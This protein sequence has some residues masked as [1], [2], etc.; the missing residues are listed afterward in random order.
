MKNIF[1]IILSVA[2]G[3][4]F[5]DIKGRAG[6]AEFWVI[7]LVYCV[8]PFL[9]VNLI[10]EGSIYMVCLF[11]LVLLMPWIVWSVIVRRFHD[12]NMSGWWM[13]LILPLIILPFAEG[14]KQNNRFNAE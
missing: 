10:N 13:C 1:N 8:C 11:Y 6:L 4:K 3:D 9:A 14:N 2:I 5:F 12:I 7:M